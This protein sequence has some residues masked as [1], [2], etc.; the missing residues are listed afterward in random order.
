MKLNETKAPAINLFGG[1]REIRTLDH[2]VAVH[3]L[4]HLAT[5]PENKKPLAI[6]VFDQSQGRIIAYAKLV[7]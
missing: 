7:A 4:N 6:L 2:G 1:S 3:C 5:D